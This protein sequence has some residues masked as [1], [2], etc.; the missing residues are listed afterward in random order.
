MRDVQLALL[1]GMERNIGPIP[2]S[3]YTGSNADL[4]AAI[5]GLYLAGSV[6]DVTFGNGETAGGWWR[7]FTPDPF[8]FH[9]LEFDGVDF[10][11]LPETDRS[12]ATVCFDPPYIAA[13]GKSTRAGVDA[14][15]R[16]RFGL[17]HGDEYISQAKLRALVHDGLG[18]VCRVADEY[19]L[20]KCMEFVGGG[21]F[22]DMPYE[23]TRWALEE[24]GMVKHDVIVHHTGPGPGG[25]NISE[26]KRARRVH[27]YLLV[28]T[29]AA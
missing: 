22:T 20:V 23:V 8:T 17:G 15:F 1:E 18:E 12:V 11:A 26:I 19:V 10:R 25:H 4:M 5:S 24:F 2:P 6:L 27:S 28:F 14:T 9:D 7:R 3:V 21:G 13:G 16:T 29:H